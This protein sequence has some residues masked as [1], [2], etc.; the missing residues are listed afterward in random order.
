MTVVVECIGLKF[1]EENLKKVSEGIESG[2]SLKQILVVAPNK[3]Q[4]VK[5]LKKFGPDFKDLGGDDKKRPREI[6]GNEYE[7]AG[8]KYPNLQCLSRQMY[9]CLLL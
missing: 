4:W 2:K 8:M 6:A 3:A 9:C 5:L 7:E 1:S